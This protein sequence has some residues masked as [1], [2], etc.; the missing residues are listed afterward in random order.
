[1]T[2]V[3]PLIS[4]ENAF[5]FHMSFCSGRFWSDNLQFYLQRVHSLE[6]GEE[7]LAAGDALLLALLLVYQLLLP[8]LLL[9]PLLVSTLRAVSLCKTGGETREKYHVQDAG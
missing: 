7:G 9:G 3:I 5:S 6:Y 1:M 8:P 2:Q 4:Q